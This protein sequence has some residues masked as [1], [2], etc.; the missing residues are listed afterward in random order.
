MDIILA[1]GNPGKRREFEE[2]A[3]LYGVASVHLIAPDARAPHVAETG[4]G[5]LANARL[6][7]LAFASQYN[8]PALGDDSGLSVDAL[9]GAPGLRTARFGGPALSAEQRVELLLERLRGVPPERRGAHFVCALYLAFPDGTR[10]T[11]HG[12]VYGRIAER[13]AGSQGFGY[14]PIFLLPNLGCTLAELPPAEK[15]RRS[16]RGRAVRRLLRRLAHDRGG[17]DLV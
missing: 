13:P 15:H 16:H 8:S 10:V 9:G 5:Y 1:S 2:I 12:F 6:K 14:D 4:R 17:R 3:A 7:A 11:A